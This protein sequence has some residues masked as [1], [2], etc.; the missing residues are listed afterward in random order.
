MAH[1]RGGCF[2]FFYTTLPPKIGPRYQCLMEKIEQQLPFLSPR[3]RT[4]HP[5][6]TTKT[7]SCSL[8]LDLECIFSK[9]TAQGSFFLRQSLSEFGASS[10]PKASSQGCPTCK[11]IYDGV[12]LYLAPEVDK[13]DAL[14]E[15]FAYEHDLTSIVVIPRHENTGFKKFE[16]DMYS[17]PGQRC[18]WSAIKPGRH[19][20]SSSQKTQTQMMIRSWLEECVSNHPNTC[21][22]NRLVSLPKRVVDIESGPLKLRLIDGDSILASYVALSHC[23]GNEQPFKTTRSN[24]QNLME[25]INFFSLPQTFQDAIQIARWMHIKYIWI[26][27]LCIV[28]DDEQDWQQQ[29]SQMASIF[30][31]SYFTIAATRASSGKI[32]CFPEPRTDDLR[33]VLMLEESEAKP[34]QVY[35]RKRINHQPIFGSDGSARAGYPLLDRAWCFQELIL[36]T[37]TLHFTSDEVVFECHNGFQCECGRIWSANDPS[38]LPSDN[39]KMGL[40]LASAT[41]RITASYLNQLWRDIVTQYTTKKLTHDRDILVALSGIA[42]RMPREITGDYIGGLWKRSTLSGLLWQSRD[43][44]ISRRPKEY[45]A[46]SFSWASRL[47]PVIYPVANKPLQFH[48]IILRSACKVKTPGQYGECIS[49]SIKILEVALSPCWVKRVSIK[50]GQPE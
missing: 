8:C 25:D 26:D 27:S 10:R 1:E 4:K 9:D 39:L 24:M 12:E 45:T 40:R 44:S 6:K 32:G 49:G 28:Q 30:Q 41:Q 16:L 37:R 50:S 42:S 5:P 17:I 38:M 46:P 34:V 31:N 23:W 15:V 18:P 21:P 7:A 29:S 14:V 47:G 35:F 2:P 3:G 22:R 33:V 48:P 43:A 20:P 19:V 13:S 11:V 36:A